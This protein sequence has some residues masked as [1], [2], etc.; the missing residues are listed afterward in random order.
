MNISRNGPE[1]RNRDN[2]DNDHNED[3]HGEYGEDRPTGMDP[4]GVIEVCIEPRFRLTFI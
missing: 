1:D 3:N 4:E 2:R